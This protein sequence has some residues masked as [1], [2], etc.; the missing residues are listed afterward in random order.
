MAKLKKNLKLVDVFAISTGAMFSS[1]LFLL[2]GLAAAQTGMSVALAYLIAGVLMIPAMLSQAELSTAMPRA[3]GAYYFLDRAMGPLMGTIGGLGTWVALVFKSGFALIGMGA[4]LALW[5]DVPIVTVALILTVVFCL[6]NIVGA[7]ESSGLQRVLVG[8]LLVV[9]AAFVLV[10][11]GRAGGASVTVHLDKPFL[12]DGVDGLLATVGFVFVSYAGLTKVASVAEEVDDPDRNIPRGMVLSLVA[13]TIAYTTAVAVITLVLPATDLHMDLAPVAT[14]AAVLGGEY[15][16]I[17]VAL[18]VVAAVAAFASTANAGI[19]SAS[20][21]P[22]AM[23]RDQ[24]VPGGFARLGRFKTPTWGIVATSLAIAVCVTAFDVTMVAKL[25]SA[26]QLVLFAL[27]NL[28]V[29]VMRESRLSYYRPGFASPLYPWMQIAGIIFPFW[30]IAEM[31]WVAMAF[32]VGLIVACA[33][34]YALYA[35]SRVSRAGAIFHVFERLGR[36][37]WIALDDELRGILHEKGLKDD[38]P[39]DDLILRAPV[40]DLEGRLRFAEVARAVAEQFAH[41]TDIPPS[42]LAETFVAENRIGMMPVV[43]GAAFPHHQYVGISRPE[44]VVARV[45]AG[46]QF[47]IDPSQAHVRMDAPVYVFV[48]LLSPDG[49]AGR[50]YRFLAHLAGRFEEVVRAAKETDAD[51]AELALGFFND[52][53]FVADGEEDHS[54]KVSP[55]A[56]SNSATTQGC[57]SLRSTDTA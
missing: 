27:L 21:Y 34:W 32:T 15:A 22:L 7:K 18:V 57:L 33:A 12:L 16:T 5:M 20:R 46:V 30:L 26:F 24:L 17:A 8:V 28:C 40:L 11:L 2:P 51:P 1:G 14:A 23:G 53:L 37:R 13:A 29:I 10:G 36:R 44:L 49:D 19:M 25:A 6:V 52:E 38:D 42:E 54:P 4:Y 55:L 35:S 48:F 9:V 47:D 31:G 43:S 41:R 50:H 39:L 56:A 45:P 3:G